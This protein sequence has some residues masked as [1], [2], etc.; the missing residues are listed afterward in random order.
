[1]DIVLERSS[2]SE[3]LVSHQTTDKSPLLV[4]TAELLTATDKEGLIAELR[5]LRQRR[6]TAV[7]FRRQHAMR[8]GSAFLRDALED[9]GMKVCLIGFAGG[10][11]GTLGRTYEQAVTDTRLALQYATDMG[12]RGVVV[13]PG[14]RGFHTYNHAERTIRDGLND[15]LDDALRLRIDMLL[16]I[17]GIFG[18]RN[19]VF[20]P[21]SC[22]VLDWV[23]SLDC[24]RIKSLMVLRGRHPW[25]RLPDC[26]ER[27][28]RSGGALRASRRCRITVGRHN[29]TS[30]IV[31][32]L[33]DVVVPV[34]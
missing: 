13:V 16:P 10:F 29:L 22:S 4:S 27:C 7:S 30:R 8:I 28:L 17:N 19:D 14:S 15:C 1:M 25:K 12:A 11:T 3:F 34:S 31:S 33:K 20:L 5:Q 21:D 9:Y 32:Q 26:W 2:G 24:H 6:I 18:H 23:E